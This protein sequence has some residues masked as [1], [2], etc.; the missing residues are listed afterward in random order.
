M[1]SESEPNGLTNTTLEAS[2]A[3][4]IDEAGIEVSE[5]DVVMCHKYPDLVCMAPQDGPYEPSCPKVYATCWQYRI[6]NR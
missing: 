6:W 3:E 1:S 2:T 5:I 4:S